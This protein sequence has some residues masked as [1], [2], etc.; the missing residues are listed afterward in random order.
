MRRKQ[1]FQMTKHFSEMEHNDK[2]KITIDHCEPFRSLGKASRDLIVRQSSVCLLF[3][4]IFLIFLTIKHK[5]DAFYDGLSM[6]T[7]EMMMYSIHRT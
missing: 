6:A 4:R 2:N 5:A 3:F 1:K 7:A